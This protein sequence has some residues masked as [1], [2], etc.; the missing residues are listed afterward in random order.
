VPMDGQPAVR[1]KECIK[2]C[3][4]VE[5]VC[6]ILKYKEDFEGSHRDWWDM[7]LLWETS[8]DEV[9][10][11]RKRARDILSENLAAVRAVYETLLERHDEVIPGPEIEEIIRSAPKG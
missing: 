4:G 8:K 7:L 9:G 1:E 2:Y 10:D 11:F 6:I 3:G 5:G